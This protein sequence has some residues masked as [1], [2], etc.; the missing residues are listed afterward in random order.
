MG[1]MEKTTVSGKPMD[2]YVAMPE[3]KG[4]F[5]TVCVMWHRGALD[6]FTR[7]RADRLAAAGFIAAVPDLF[8]R[9]PADIENPMTILDDIELEA[10]IAA[11][12]EHMK[13]KAECNGT[14]AIL[15]HCMGGRIAFLGAS[16]NPAFSAAVIY[17]S[18]NMFK[19]WGKGAKPPFELLSEIKGPVIGFYGNDDK[20]PSP[21]DVNKI[22]TELTRLGITHEFHRYDGAGHAFQN[23][24]RPEQ[25]REAAEKD[26]WKRTL[27]FLKKE[28]G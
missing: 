28:I 12:V 15:G 26:S 3:G 25:Y 23:F 10:D 14:F 8:H 27:D 9:A 18:G 4:P 7:D 1:A 11:T 24:V 2:I 19:V 5:P 22:D 21:D 6:D 13:A 17:Y 16:V 20:N